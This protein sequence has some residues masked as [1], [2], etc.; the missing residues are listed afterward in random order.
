M[1][2][3]ENDKSKWKDTAY[4][5]IKRINIVEMSILHKAIYSSNKIS[6]KWH[7]HGTRRNSPKI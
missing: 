6:V 2:K 4:S 5:W 3:T 1:K 7:F